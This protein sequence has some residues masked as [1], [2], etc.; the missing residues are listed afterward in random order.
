[1]CK[2]RD[3]LLDK[4]KSVFSG[5]ICAKL[6]WKKKKNFIIKIDVHLKKNLNSVHKE[7]N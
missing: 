4:L 6:F 7:T 5:G 2:N 3:S 1:M